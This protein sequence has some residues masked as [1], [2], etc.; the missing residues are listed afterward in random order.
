MIKYI[1]LFGVV[2]AAA[3]S[4]CGESAG[5]ATITLQAQLANAGST[6]RAILVQ[7]VGTDTSSRIDTVTAPVGSS[8]T[9]FAQRQSGTGWRAIIA[10]NLANGAV[11]RLVVP[12]KARASNY[13]PSILDVADAGFADLQAGS[14]ALSITP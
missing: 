1:A 3:L 10:G 14:R 2:A 8:Y 7:I 6:D 11:L 12:G 5:P 4:D 9:V 13:T